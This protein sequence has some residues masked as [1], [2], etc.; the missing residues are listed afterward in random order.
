MYTTSNH[1][2]YTLING[3]HGIIRTLDLP[4]YLT[5]IKGNN[6]FCLDRELRPR[7]LTIDPTEFKFKLA[8]VNRRYDE[9]LH[10]VRTSKLVG[11]SIISYLQK[12]GY[13]EVALHFV[14]DNKTRFALAIE[15]GNL[16]V[17]SSELLTRLLTNNKR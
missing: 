15:S 4:V 1:I 8:L 11:Q 16:E 9:V 7:I 12:K 13:P 3:D 2:K 14:K 5:R 10:M 17:T 6:V